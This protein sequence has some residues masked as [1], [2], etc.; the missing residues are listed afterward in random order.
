MTYA[1]A[2]IKENGIYK[3]A[4]PGD[5]VYVESNDFE[6][7]Y[8]IRGV[9]YN[10]CALIKEINWMSEFDNAGDIVRVKESDLEYIEHL[11]LDSQVAYQFTQFCLDRNEA[12]NKF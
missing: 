10:N 6:Y 8:K 4:L 9:S 5:I 11:V 3:N 1:I 12:C 7:F 2:K